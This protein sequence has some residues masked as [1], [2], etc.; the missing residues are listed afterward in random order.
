MEVNTDIYN[1]KGSISATTNYVTG[2]FNQVAT[3]YAN[4][5]INVTVSDIVI[6]TSQSPYTST[7]SSGMLSQFTAYRQG[8]NGDLAQLLSYQASGGIAYPDGL[9]RS[10]PDYSMSYAGISSTYQMY[11]PIVGL[12]WYVPTNLGI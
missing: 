12:S 10:N 9:C 11:L 7:T 4:E 3:L 8:F 1:N 2:L 5:Q 6:W